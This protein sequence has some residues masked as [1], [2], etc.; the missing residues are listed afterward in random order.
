MAIYSTLVN[1]VAASKLYLKEPISLNNL[2]L[3][4][5]DVGNLDIDNLSS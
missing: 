4:A 2:G 3:D 1:K 5:L